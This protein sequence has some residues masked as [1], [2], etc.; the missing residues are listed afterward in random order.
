MEELFTTHDIS[1]LL[2]VDPSTVSK[3]ID[4]GILMAFRT[5]GRH[6]RVRSADLRNFLIAHRMPVPEE[7]GSGVIRLLVVD[8]EK[9][10]LDGLRRAFKAFDAQV[11][12]TT[13]TSGVEALLL[14]SEQKPHGLLVDLSMPDLN[15]FEVCR[16]IRLRQQLESVKL[17]TMSARHSPELVEQ[18]IRA[19]AVACLSKPID[20]QRVMD[21][22]HVQP[23][24]AM[25]GAAE[26]KHVGP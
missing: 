19:G 5:P 18:S 6:R 24:L 22:F 1:R 14:V 20:P 2:Q 15:G 26:L 16:R 3:W 17:I 11:E 12:M 7:L 9:P 8:D 10:V 21:L 25:N 4:K 23:V 13:T